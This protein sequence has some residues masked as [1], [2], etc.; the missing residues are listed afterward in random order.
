MAATT[1]RGCVTLSSR[2]DLISSRCTATCNKQAPRPAH[3]HTSNQSTEQGPEKATGTVRGQAAGALPSFSLSLSHTH[4]KT[5]TD[6]HTYALCVRVPWW[7]LYLDDGA[8]KVEGRAGGEQLCHGGQLKRCLNRVRNQ[9][10]LGRLEGLP[11][12]RPP[13]RAPALA[14]L[15]PPRPVQRVHTH[16]LSVCAWHVVCVCLP[17]LSLSLSLYVRSTPSCCAEPTGGDK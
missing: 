11:A 8:A 7:G 10:P 3:T 9:C 16:T 6:T 4:K 14:S 2:T 13:P 17:S 5:H 1:S 12:T 15:H